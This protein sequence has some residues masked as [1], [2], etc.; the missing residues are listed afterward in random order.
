MPTHKGQDKTRRKPQQSNQQKRGTKMCR[1]KRGK[2][3]S[4]T[5]HPT[6]LARE[7]EAKMGRRLEIS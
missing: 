5:P 7:G 4:I 6:S 1:R 2:P 3:S